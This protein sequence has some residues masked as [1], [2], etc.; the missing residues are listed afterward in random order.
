DL[1]GHLPLAQYL[2]GVDLDIGSLTTYPAHDVRLVDHDPTMRKN[3]ARSF[4]APGEDDG[5]RRSGDA[6]AGRLDRRPHVLHGVVDREHPVDRA[7]RRVD[8]ERDRLV[9]ILR[10]Q[11]EELSHNQIG[12]LVVDRAP[13]EDDPVTEQSG[14]DVERTLATCS[15]LDDGGYQHDG[16]LATVELHITLTRTCNWYVAVHG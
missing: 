8:V 1:I 2:G 16:L 9:G 11:M 6:D 12:R 4:R 15:L 7:A 10:L 14:V 13:Q 3:R 5:C